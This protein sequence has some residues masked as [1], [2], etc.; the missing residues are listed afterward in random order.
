MKLDFYYF[1][2]Q[3]PLNDTMIQL[4]EEYS[5]VIDVHFYD[6]T[7]DYQL[8][9]KMEIFY[10]TLIVLNEHKRYYSPL[11]KPFLEQVADGKYPTENPFCPT[12][13]RVKKKEIIEQLNQDNIEFACDCCGKKTESNSCKKAMFLKRFNFESYGYIHKD[14]NGS[15]IGGAEYLPAKYIPYNV[16][17]NDDIAFITCVYMSDTKFDYKSAPLLAL[18]YYLKQFYSKVMAISDEIGIFPNGDLKFFMD[19]GYSDEGVIYEDKDYCRLHLVT[20]VLI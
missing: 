10:P 14:I 8:S 6:L 4:L 19:N 2:Y 11:S 5:D 15:L 9:K 13:S 1:S 18:E 16:P 17:H 12:L 3:C 7:N 20:K